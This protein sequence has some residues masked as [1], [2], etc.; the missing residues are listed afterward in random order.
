M[1]GKSTQYAISCAAITLLLA[2][3]QIPSAPRPDVR[4][5]MTITCELFAYWTERGYRRGP[6]VEQRDTAYRLGTICN[7][8]KAGRDPI[9][10]TQANADWLLGVERWLEHSL[11]FSARVVE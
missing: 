9:A 4:V 2:G 6:T 11:R 7:E 8:L 5:Q 1:P 10:I 3:C